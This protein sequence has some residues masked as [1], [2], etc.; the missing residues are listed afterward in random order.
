MAEQRYEREIDELLRRLEH[1]SPSPL[2]FRRRS[3]PWVR[4]RRALEGVLA[5][6]S[7]VERL[8]AL[9]VVLLL[10]TLVLGIFAPR[11]AAPLA[12]LAV[13]AFVLA[14]GLSVW[15]GAS[16]KRTYS[17]QSGRHYTPH[18]TADWNQLVWRARAWLRRFRR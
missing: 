6:Q 3:A 10:G 12:G 17:A 7:A 16:G 11:F 8:M 18:A 14:L 5:V 2:P 4:A 9:A 13:G 15:N 1:D